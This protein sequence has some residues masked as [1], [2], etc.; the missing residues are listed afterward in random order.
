[1]LDWFSRRLR[2]LSLQAKLTLF[3]AVLVLFAISV[4]GVVAWRLIDLLAETPRRLSNLLARAGEYQNLLE[5]AR[6]TAEVI[7]TRPPLQRSL[8][9]EDA[10]TLGSLVQT[11]LRTRSGDF[12]AVVDADGDT[13]VALERGGTPQS[14]IPLRSDEAIARA[15]AGLP[16][17]GLEVVPGESVRAVVALPVRSGEEVVGAVLVASFLDNVLAERLKLATSFDVTFYAGD[18]ATATTLRLSDG[19]RQVGMQVP[20]DV[21]MAVMNEGLMVERVIRG[22]RGRLLV[23]YSPLRGVDGQLVGMFSI[24]APVAVLFETRTSVLG[25][26][27][28]VVAA[29]LAI[30]LTAAAVM[31]RALSR[32]VHA[33]AT[34]VQRIGEG[35][36]T[37]PVPVAGEDEVG[38]LARAVEEM[39]RRLLKHAE[40]QEQLN[41]L[42]DQYLFNVAHELKTPLT[43]LAASVELLAQDDGT[44]PDAERRHFVTMVQRS[45]ARL[46]SLVDNLL[47]L[48]SL[49]TGRFHITPRPAVLSEI[50][51]EAV[52]SVQS[53]LEARRQRVE[54]HLPE[55]PPVVLAD[56][57]R[58]QQVLVN[59][60]SNANKYGP[61][62]DT[63][64]IAAQVVDGQVRVSVT[65]HGPGIPSE[66]QPH[67]FEAYFRSAMARQLTPGVGLGLAIVKAIV[68]AHGGR[69][70]VDSAPQRGTTVWFT[71]PLAGSPAG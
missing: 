32:P 27:G 61:E 33:L 51:T 37:I 16:A 8:V 3:A 30:A 41:R 29:T 40:E 21:S 57:R 64:D 10:S 19:T 2:A 22:P 71:L 47:D 45:T 34:S 68:E 23:R 7:S 36:L 44:L 42:K 46:Q 12:V 49:R 67:L 54:L 39:R 43:T 38:R 31:A 56:E 17:Q 59:L 53:L 11:V 5:N 18:R 25:V 58:V 1:M 70:G 24:S 15:L 28:P 20:P 35:D 26:F 9:A 52:A 69:V 13:I 66:E 6:I 62:G 50:A 60:L 14:G 55:P 63:I 48:G 65:D 4:T